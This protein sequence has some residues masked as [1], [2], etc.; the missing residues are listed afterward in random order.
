MN[1]KKTIILLVGL[2]LPVGIFLFLKIFGENK[3]D[4]QPLFQTELPAEIKGCGEVTVPYTLPAEI[5]QEFST[6]ESMVSVVLV[7]SELERLSRVQD[8]FGSDPVSIMRVEAGASRGG[9]SLKDCVFLLTAPYDV[10]L[11]DQQ[12][13]I[14]GQYSSDDRNEVDRLILEISIMLNK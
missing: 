9:K 10:V 8:Q 1:I 3:F 12:G 6:K 5:V 14:R 2:V 7:G 13:V 4:V 11:L